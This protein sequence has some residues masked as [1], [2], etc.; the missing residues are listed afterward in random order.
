MNKFKALAGGL[1]L[2]LALTAPGMVMAFPDG[3][4]GPEGHHGHHGGF[5]EGR[6]L[7]HLA[8]KLDLTEG[9]KAQ[10]EANREAGKAARKAAREE[11]HQVHEQLREAIE[12]GADQATLDDLAAKLGRLEVQKM[13]YMHERKVQFESILTDEQKAKLEEMKAEG[14]ARFEK[15]K[16]QWERKR[17]Q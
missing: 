13:Q 4:H 10:M 2:G 17:D 16:E 8:E 6:M 14:K 7:E 9:Q 11:M 3:G 15:R 1:A 5:H 12:S